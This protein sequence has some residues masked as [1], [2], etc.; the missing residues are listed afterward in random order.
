MLCDVCLLHQSLVLLRLV[1]LLLNQTLLLCLLL[2]CLIHRLLLHITR[3]SQTILWCGAVALPYHVLTDFLGQQA[4][5]QVGVVLV[6]LRQ[7]W[8]AAQGQRWEAITLQSLVD[9]GKL[10]PGAG[11]GAGGGG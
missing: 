4:L 6:R 3:L 9:E 7:R 8:S 2:L 5:D 1:L 10:L 11:Q